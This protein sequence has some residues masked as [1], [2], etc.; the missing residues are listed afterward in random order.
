MLTLQYKFDFL[1]A[2]HSLNNDNQMILII[3]LVSFT[4]SILI[5]QQIHTIASKIQ[6]TSQLKR[7]N[8][9]HNCFKTYDEQHRDEF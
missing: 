3:F 6:I 4:F 2:V 7:K 9:T 5:S 1:S 8:K